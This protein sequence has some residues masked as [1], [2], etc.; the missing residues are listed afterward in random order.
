MDGGCVLAVGDGSWKGKTAVIFI[1]VDLINVRWSRSEIAGSGFLST[2]RHI[3]DGAS[4]AVAVSHLKTAIDITK[5]IR[6]SSPSLK[7]AELELRLSG[8][9]RALADAEISLIDAQR[10]LREKDGTIAELRAALESKATLMRRN[11][12]Y[13]RVGPDGQ[14]R[15]AAF[16]P[17]CWED[18]N[19]QRNLVMV[20]MGHTR[21]QSCKAIYDEARTGTFGE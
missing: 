15:G 19:K 4:I 16:C 10:E 17:R 20:G 3:V 13:Y 5:L 12:A 8:V 21:C 1:S 2:E 11:D 18:E 6:E 9:I 7:K 14:P